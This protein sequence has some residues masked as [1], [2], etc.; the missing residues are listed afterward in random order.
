MKPKLF[1]AV[2]LLMLITG[3]ALIH[4]FIDQARVP[5]KNVQARGIIL[6]PPVVK[7]LAFEFKGIAADFLFVRAS[8]YFGGKIAARELADKSD[9]MWLY[10]NLIV[11]TDLDPYFEDPYYF[12]N[13]IFTWDA[14]MYSEANSLLKKCVEARNWD[15]QYPFYLGFNKFYFLHEYREAADYLLAASKRPGAYEFLPTLAARLYSSEG[16][17]ETAI[18]FLKVFVDN[19]RDERTRKNYETRLEAFKKIL[20]LE[21]AV[22]RYRHKIGKLPSNLQILVQS[23][24]L[25]EIPKDPYGGYFYLGKDGSV[26]TTSKLVFPPNSP[27]TNSGAV[28]QQRN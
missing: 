16:G 4:S 18:V 22:S 11:I 3:Y 13:A 8:Q 21:R 20:F 6:P 12:G 1:L 17:T 24:I 7:L 15:W 2:F 28:N 26:Q 19:A 9:M 23:G 25:P 14:G 10:R 27:N 5:L